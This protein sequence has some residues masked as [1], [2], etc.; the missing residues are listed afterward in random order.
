[1]SFMRRE[2]ARK[3]PNSFSTPDYGRA[4]QFGLGIRGFSLIEVL[5]VVIIVGILAGLGAA[6]YAKL[7]R[8]TKIDNQ[9]RKMQTDLMNVKVKAMTKNR[10]HFLTLASGGYTAY[11]DT[12][13]DGNL[14]VGTDPA[15]LR[16]N[17][18]LNLSSV[19][20]QEFLPI[21]WSGTAQLDF[22][23]KGLSTTSNT[24]CLFSDVSTRYDCVNITPTRITLGKLANQGVCSAANCQ[25]Q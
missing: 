15:V 22:T 11:D 4:R 18:A 7:M 19:T 10:N 25:I 9:M 13:E 14:T 6:N 16:S 1:M 12:N 20:S 2:S 8:K 21:V 17:Q 3:D 24:V 5:V 23:P